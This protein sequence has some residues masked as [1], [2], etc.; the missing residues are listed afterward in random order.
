MG[1]HKRIGQND[2]HVGIGSRNLSQRVA[3]LLDVASA[4]N[5]DGNITYCSEVLRQLL[6][7]AV[8]GGCRDDHVR[9]AARSV[10]AT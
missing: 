5:L 9:N 6:R 10:T 4:M 2:K 3:Q 7:P 8:R 1:E